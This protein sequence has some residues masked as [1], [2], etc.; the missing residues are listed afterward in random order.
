[1]SMILEKSLEKVD[2][3]GWYIDLLTEI[4]L[5]CSD[6]IKP[7]RRVMIHLLGL[8]ILRICLLPPRGGM[9]RGDG[10]TS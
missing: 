8:I 4:V 2:S 5:F 6:T 10:N 3:D 9:F 7:F 1:M